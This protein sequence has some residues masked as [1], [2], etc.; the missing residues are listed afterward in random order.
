M[1]DKTTVQIFGEDF[2][3]CS[4][5]KQPYSIKPEPTHKYT[6]ADACVADFALHIKRNQV[7]QLLIMPD[8]DEFDL[9]AEL[10]YDK[11]P[12]LTPFDRWVWEVYFGY[13]CEKRSGYKL[14]VNYVKNANTAELVF[15]QVD[16]VTCSEILKQCTRNIKVEAEE[17][18]P[19]LLSYRNGAVTVGVFGITAQ[20]EAAVQRGI[21]GF[22]KGCGVTDIGVAKIAVNGT[23]PISETV[24]NQSFIIPRTDGGHYDYELNLTVERIGE[25][26]PVYE[27]GYCL[28][29]GVYNNRD[30]MQS[31][32][33]W[34]REH[35]FFRGLYFSFGT[36]KLYVYNGEL[37]FSDNSYEN[38]KNIISG[39]D[40]PYEGKL[41]VEKFSIP[42]KVYIG[43]DRRFSFCAGNQCSDRMFTYDSCGKL[44][45]TG[46]AL[47]EPCFFEVSSD[48]HKEIVSRLP[49]NLVN[50]EEAVFHAEKNHYFFSAEKPMFRVDVF[51]KLSSDYLSFAA[52]LQTVYF[53]KIKDLK[54]EKIETGGNV[55]G[56]CGYK[57]YSFTVTC[58]IHAQG[59]YHMEFRC[60]YG[61]SAVYK[62]TSAFEIFDE[63][64]DESPQ[65]TAGLPMIYCGD[66]CAAYYPTYNL[67]NQKPDFNIMHYINCSL[68]TPGTAEKRRAWELT[69]IY[70]RKLLVWMTRRGLLNRNDTFENYPGLAVNADY[71]NYVYPGIEDS[72]I[73]Y[74]YDLWKHAVFDAEKVRT[75]YRAFLAENPDIR[76][77]FPEFDDN[78]NVDEQRWA[79]IPGESF[80]RLVGYIN[81]KTEPL[82]EKQ[83]EEIKK[84]NP[85]VKRFSYGPYPVYGIDN[86]GAYDTKWFGFSKQGLS[87]VFNGGFLQLEDYPFA[88]GYQ[89]HISAWNMMTIKQEWKDL[90]I[91]P[92]LYDSF[93][94]GCPDGA[95]ANAFP[96]AS[97]SFIE[98]YQIVT[99][100][101]E[102]L[103]NTPI[104]E[105]GQFRYWSD[106]ILQ[107]YEYKSY[108]PEK[109][110]ECILR[111]WKIYLDNKPLR[112]LKGTAFV[113]EFDC[114]EDGR[115]VAVDTN[116]IFNK[117][118][119]GMCVV[120][121]VNAEAGLPQGFVLK[122][123]SLQQLDKTQTD[124]LVLPSLRK[125]GTE[126]KEQ[127]RRLYHDGVA[128]IA[129]GDVSGL[130][131]IFGV[132]SRPVTK[133]IHRINYNG[134]SELV[135]PSVC[136][137]PYEANGAERIVGAENEGIIF[138]NGRALLLNACLSDV[139][140]DSYTAFSYAGRAN[141]SKLIRAAIGDFLKS[142][143][144][145][146]AHC[147]DRCGIEIV[148]TVNGDTLVVL[149]DYSPY[150]NEKPRTVGVRFD[151]LNVS[152]VENLWYD[153]HDINMNFFERNGRIDGF[154]AVIRPREVLIF[155]LRITAEDNV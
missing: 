32:D 26:H 83:W 7:K 154:S 66:G 124:V 142:V 60:L 81:D 99:Q 68:D 13:N 58:D 101:Y 21:L 67:A 27:V 11:P 15:Y 100:I 121:E 153:A 120:H 44:L 110:Y 149:T 139:G 55:F 54:I 5:D 92:E 116:A 48:P 134:E 23:K 6:N 155:K 123:D 94:D 42:G 141:I 35:D 87:N 18:Y 2:K 108:E 28:T 59:V 10:F 130:E 74:R 4:D 73:Y 129:T 152:A 125:V 25:T 49:K 93:P 20:V 85:N 148:K 95:T 84:I 64:T 31:C 33:V 146:L 46:K 113:T 14:S 140:I 90:R 102:Y 47:E 79:M 30:D 98:P 17:R 147:D 34:S 39:D 138:R 117:S 119:T 112:P 132:T 65:E 126:I 104:F 135:Y 86:S 89:T 75:L 128:L 36:D 72:S 24:Y 109:R 57:K 45:F 122:W 51:S 53:E 29:G 82:F 37:K 105:N 61:T 38:F 43:Y 50:Y 150:S 80:E 106:N 131:D 41:T 12:R 144:E 52:E 151:N 40:I 22:A 56:N 145:P 127:I 115:S 118:Q 3:N 77:D 16:G 133:K 107:V 63:S 137:L 136:R 9:S 96:P 97:E 71:I 62:H 103:Y 114:A 88:C 70:R 143:S 111:S 1:S 19:L 8:V 69:H 78:G 91:A 76:N